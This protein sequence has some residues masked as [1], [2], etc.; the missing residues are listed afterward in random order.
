MY[1]FERMNSHWLDAQRKIVFFDLPPHSKKKKKKIPLIM[2]VT[3]LSFPE[4][5]S[6]ILKS[7]SSSNLWFFFQLKLN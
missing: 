6:H 4:E 1:A 2:F 5:S 7:L 3:L